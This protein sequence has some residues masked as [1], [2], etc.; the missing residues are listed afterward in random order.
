[1]KDRDQD[2]ERDPSPFDQSFRTASSSAI[3]ITPITPHA[4]FSFGQ[5]AFTRAIRSVSACASAAGSS[6]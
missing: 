2:D 4:S 3:A 6:A 5:F 1:M